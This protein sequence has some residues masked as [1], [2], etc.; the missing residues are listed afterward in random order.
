MNSS[1]N[2]LFRPFLSLVSP[3]ACFSLLFSPPP[4][5][6]PP[7]ARQRAPPPPAA[8]GA[9]ARGGRGGRGVPPVKSPEIATDGRVTFRLRAPNAREVAVSIGGKQIPM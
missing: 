8:A 9:A 3:I 5:G 1:I 7:A 6:P 4:P 2:R